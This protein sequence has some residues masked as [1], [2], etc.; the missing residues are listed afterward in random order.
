MEERGFKTKGLQGK[1]YS[2]YGDSIDSARY[3]NTIRSLTNAFLQRC[4]DQKRLLALIQLAEKK[5]SF[6]IKRSLSKEDRELISHIRNSLKESLS[7]YTRQVKQHLKTMP[8]SQR[9]DPVIKTNEEQYHLFMVEIELTNR[10]NEHAF[11]KSAYKFALIAHCLRD[12]RPDCA[13]EPGET[14]D[15]CMGCTEEC[16][17]HLGSH[18]MKKYNIRPYISITMD[19]KKLFNNLKA[20]HQDIG[21]LGIA[22]VPE[23]VHGMRLCVETG[24]IPVGI[25]LDANR[26]ARWMKQAHE[27]SFSVKE[28]E[29]LLGDA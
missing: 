3:Y 23:L 18:I 22:C 25:P 24:I 15:E 27:S 6:R 13:S 19:L 5:R 21:A 8:L 2:L 12:F 17:I 28:L 29:A 20:E 4:P 9:F 11:K 10:V 1:T 7:E 26:C 14:E 16:F